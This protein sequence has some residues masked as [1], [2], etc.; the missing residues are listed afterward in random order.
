MDLLKELE[1][2][3]NDIQSLIDEKL[4]DYR[5]T[6]FN[7]SPQDHK[8]TSQMREYYNTQFEKIREG[9]FIDIDRRS[10]KYDYIAKTPFSDIN[11]KDY[12]KFILM[13]EFTQ[14]YNEF[15]KINE[16]YQ[17]EFFD[18]QQS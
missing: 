15:Y 13:S 11:I 10:F 14:R 9:I 7:V 12:I 18:T 16:D 5:S 17:D 1:I 8:N 2:H 3:K 4:I 6:L